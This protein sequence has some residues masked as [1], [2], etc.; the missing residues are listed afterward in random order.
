[1][2]RS[3]SEKKR[4]ISAVLGQ[5]EYLVLEEPIGL[6]KLIF[7]LVF[8]EKLKKAD[9]PN[10]LMGWLRAHESI[11]LSYSEY[12]KLDLSARSAYMKDL[13]CVLGEYFDTIYFT[14]HTDD[15]TEEQRD[16]L[17]EKWFNW[18]DVI[19]LVLHS[20]YFDLLYRFIERIAD[21]GDN[22]IAIEVHRR[23]VIVKYGTDNS[24]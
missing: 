1:M 11:A 14:D 15:L 9:I 24:H 8:I 19:E 5:A 3:R 18:R 4:L 17:E 10:L 23:R 21:T 16:E 20:D 2:R 13:E 6:R 22:I 12:C 7:D